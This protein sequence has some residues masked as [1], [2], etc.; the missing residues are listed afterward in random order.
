MRTLLAIFGV[1]ALLGC[2]DGGSKEPER[3][4][5]PVVVP[6]VVMRGG[7]DLYG[8]LGLTSME[9]LIAGSPII[10]R[11]TFNSVRLVGV[12]S[13][14]SITPG[15][16]PQFDG[17]VGSLE[18]TFDVIEYLKGTG[19]SQVKGVAYGFP[20]DGSNSVVATSTT[21]AAELARRLLDL[22][23]KRWDDREAV[24]FLR[25]APTIGT[26][27]DLG[28]YWLGEVGGGFRQV[29]V[30]STEARVWLPDVVA[31]TATSTGAVA[32]TSSVEQRF[33]LN[34]PAYP[35]AGGASGASASSIS[36]SALKAK[37]AEIEAEVARG[38]DSQAYRD[39]VVATYQRN[40]MHPPGS[41]PYKRFDSMVESGLATGTIVHTDG[42][43][44]MFNLT[45]FGET[46]PATGGYDVWLEGRDA[47]LFG[48]RYPGYIYA[49]RPLPDGEYR[50]FE[51]ARP[52]AMVVCDGY[53]DGVRD[54]YEYVITVTA[55]AGTLAESFF[56]PYAS[57]TAV[58]GTTTVGS[59]SWQS[60]EV[61][62][63][64]S[65]D[66]TGHA[67]D[68]IG[69]GGTTTLS[70]SAAAATSTAGT[71]TWS[72]PTQPWKAG[73]KLM[74]RIRSLSTSTPPVSTSTP[75][76]PTPTPAPTS[77]PTPTPAPTATPTPTPAPTATPTATPVPLV[78]LTATRG[79]KGDTASV[80][81][82]AYG[83]SGFSYYRFVVCD[84]SQYDGASCSG[85]VFRSDPYYDVN[86]TGPVT[87]TGLNAGTGYGVILQV[88][89]TGETN[90]L[91]FHATLPAP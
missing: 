7:I 76:T 43:A 62:A 73:D 30:A 68:F 79:A 10:V 67:L 18:F 48:E 27:D 1:A 45:V 29:T 15:R 85:A 90:V 37:I 26:V 8:K 46:K 32:A 75:A 28:H 74:L 64:L 4:P 23:D 66:V 81:W 17:Y 78:T 91:K 80:S 89:H 53:P 22:R 31:P 56:D 20:T 21:A 6:K 58:V 54:T 13:Y 9:E 60:G 57:S 24:V 44:I 88:W 40:R 63:A 5:T 42:E 38:D 41:V 87:V 55:P 59:I 65:R 77:T 71:L 16:N 61:S 86:A 39:C 82:T 3:D 51:L 50:A 35:A 69:M 19:G 25:K 84:A 34:D 72:V 47:H 70:L 14:E 12:R 33:L 2:G 83:G 49:K 52:Y 36:L 11:A